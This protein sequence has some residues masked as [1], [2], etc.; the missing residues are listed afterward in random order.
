MSVQVNSILQL[1]DDQMAS[2]YCI[3]FPNGI[4][5]GGNWQ[6][7]SLRM[8][9][10]FDP[11]AESVNVWERFFKGFKIPKTGMLEETNKEF[12]ID[13]LIDQQ[14]EVYDALE[15]W[16][17]M[18][19]NSENGTASPDS[20]CYAPLI[21]QYE[22]KKQ[23]G[24]KQIMYDHVKIREIKRGTSDNTSGDPLRVSVTFIYVLSKNL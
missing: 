10:S 13:V 17:S 21:I 14:W 22:D 4:P 15:K 7:I 5:G 12:T 19:Y 3:I 23:K 18:S 24:V 9:Q 6:N 16:K 1:G 11:P 8:D 2:Q 20:D